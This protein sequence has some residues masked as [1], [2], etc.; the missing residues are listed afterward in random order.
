MELLNDSKFNLIE[1]K[2][3]IVN[4]VTIYKITQDKLLNIE[5]SGIL[6][7]INPINSKIKITLPNVVKGLNYS[8][9]VSEDSN[10]ELEFYSNNEIVGNNYLFR[11]D[12]KYKENINKKEYSLIIN[13]FKK[14]D[15]FK[16]I[17]DDIKYYLTEK[18]EVL[19]SV[20]SNVFNYPNNNYYKITIVNNNFKFED[21]NG[22]ELIDI[23][24]G[25]TYNLIMENSLFNSLILEE[26]TIYLK[27][28]NLN[29]NNYPKFN[30]LFYDVYGNELNELK[31]YKNTTYVLNCSDKSNITPNYNDN[32]TNKEILISTCYK[33]NKIE[34]VFKDEEEKILNEPLLLNT[35]IEY[36]FK[37]IDKNLI[38]K[39]K[40]MN[41]NNQITTND[42]I[43]FEMI[44]NASNESRGG[45]N[46]DNNHLIS[47]LIES[48]NNLVNNKSIK[49]YILESIIPEIIDMSD[50]K[51]EYLLNDNNIYKINIISSTE[52]K[53]IR[54]KYNTN[55]ISLKELAID[56]ISNIRIIDNVSD[57]IKF[58]YNNLEYN[59]GIIQNY[60]KDLNSDKK[61]NLNNSNLVN[62]NDNNY[63]YEL[64]I[65]Y[66][67]V[68]KVELYSELFKNI[69]KKELNLLDTEIDNSYSGKLISLNNIEDIEL[70]LMEPVIG[71]KYKFIITNDNSI[72]NNDE[73][74]FN[75]K[76]I[77]N[78]GLKFI[79]NDEERKEIVLYSN[80]KYRFDLNNLQYN[81][82]NYN[83][84]LSLTE[85]GIHNYGK[86]YRNRNI[87]KYYGIS[88]T[89]G[90]Y[91]EID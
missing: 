22:N 15:T 76:L 24:K 18:K 8:F 2:E 37:I 10:Y 16:F 6:Y 64:K 87:L 79:I 54:G 3:L 88:G 9:I 63:I 33:N 19:N 46:L 77:Y 78:N 45:F 25:N 61:I 48:N 86:E 4:N 90:S 11:S 66:N 27:T 50:N 42:N 43:N 31:F 36:K 83:F 1:T 49:V 75:V 14:G 7:I 56:N 68:G 91:L 55:D 69:N 35:S 72:L 62:N 73:L 41:N 60:Y 84:K 17:C 51:L 74:L 71:N 47:L 59:S 32:K 70:K 34:L 39:I 67:K 89:E 82:I 29:N 13:K 81:G 30:Y 40:L 5:D 21:I 28:E 26:Q 53:S 20:N 23:V 80:N 12:V 57:L 58:K 65:E 44:F 52:I 38:K 85:D